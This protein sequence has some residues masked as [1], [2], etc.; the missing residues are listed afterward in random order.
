MKL[1]INK[2]KDDF[3]II[4]QTL[5]QSEK[6]K[7]DL[8]NLLL[9]FGFINLIL[10]IFSISEIAFSWSINN[11][12]TLVVFVTFKVL[13]YIYITIVYFKVFK[14][15]HMSSNKYF[16]GFLMTF[17]VIGIIFPYVN[18]LINIIGY[19]INISM[20]NLM[21]LM[22][23]NSLLNITLFCISFI[24]CA[25]II[26][27]KILIFFACIIFSL[28]IFVDVFEIYINFNKLDIGVTGI[29][30]SIFTTLGYIG[31]SFLLKWRHNN[32]Y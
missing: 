25:L 1:T 13:L 27:K 23:Y 19:W 21:R 7:Y 4:R 2:A 3:E 31:L 9:K 8:S 15:V 12:M 10:S 24:I 14:A 29:I 16:L 20:E 28:Y 22:Y 18:T 30:N 17:G 5:E 11:I 26:N 6:R 32:E